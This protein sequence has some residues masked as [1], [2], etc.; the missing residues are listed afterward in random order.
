MSI[1]KAMQFKRPGSALVLV[2]IAVV[3]LTIG[4]AGLL[5]IGLSSRFLAIGTAHKIKACSAADAGLTKA[6]HEI[7]EKLKLQSLYKNSQFEAIGETL[8]YC[9][10]TFSYTIEPS[11]P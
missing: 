4:G 3:L 10:G 5:Q 1:K 6:I 9:D 11:A 8:P 2:T 7:N